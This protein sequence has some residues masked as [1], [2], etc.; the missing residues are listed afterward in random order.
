M[1]VRG[2]LK[3]RFSFPIITEG[4][5]PSSMEIDRQERRERPRYELLEMGVLWREK[6]SARERVGSVLITNA[7]IGGVQIRTREDLHPGEQVLLELGSEQGTLFLRMDVRYAERQGSNGLLVAG[8]HFCPQSERDQ[9]ALAKYIL[10]IRDRA[11]SS[12]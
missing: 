5:L 8:L 7:S 2:T 1:F 6:G 4:K 10:S 12:S 9:R 11:C 3:N